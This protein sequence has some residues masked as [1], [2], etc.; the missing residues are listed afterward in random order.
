MLTWSILISGPFPVKLRPQVREISVPKH[1]TILGQNWVSQDFNQISN[2]N[3][4]LCQISIGYEF[5]ANL[6]LKSVS[7]C[8]PRAQQGGGSIM[9]LGYFS[10]GPMSYLL[11]LVQTMSGQLYLVVILESFALA[12]EHAQCQN[13]MFCDDNARPDHTQKVNKWLEMHKIV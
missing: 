9:F 11:F 1:S 12:F 3:L 13:F 5:E 7:A 2:S 8:R 6:G 4:F 10:Y